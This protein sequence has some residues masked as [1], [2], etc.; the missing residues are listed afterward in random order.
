SI[1]QTT[2]LAQ[3]WED[4]GWS[5]GCS[6]KEAQKPT[7][8]S[9]CG[10]RTLTPLESDPSTEGGK[11]LPGRRIRGAK[12]LWHSSNRRVSGCSTP[13]LEGDGSLLPGRAWKQ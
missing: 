5:S 12:A 7:N 6:V 13:H 2:L 10:G 4:G 8:S 3:S 11:R 9:T 1:H